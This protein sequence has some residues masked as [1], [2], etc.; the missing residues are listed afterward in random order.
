MGI[1]LLRDNA[2]RALKGGSDFLPFYQKK[3]LK[4]EELRQLP[5]TE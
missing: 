4:I 3:Y 1:A 2:I 5:D